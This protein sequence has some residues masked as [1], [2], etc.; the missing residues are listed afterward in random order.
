MMTLSGDQLEDFKKTYENAFDIWLSD[1][2][3][4][5]LAERLKHLYRTVLLRSAP[6]GEEP[7]DVRP[8]WDGDDTPPLA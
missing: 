8:P 1:N 3:A 2:D 5:E 6:P 7:R 4:Q